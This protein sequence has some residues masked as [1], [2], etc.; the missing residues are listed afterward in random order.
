MM[1]SDLL[2]AVAQKLKNW[3]DGVKAAYQAILEK[4]GDVTNDLSIANLPAAIHSI[5][6]R[7]ENKVIT[8]NGVYSPSE[9]Y[10]GLGEVE[11]SLK[12]LAYVPNMQINENHIQN[13]RWLLDSMIDTSL[14]TYTNNMIYN[15][16]SLT[17]LDTSGWNLSNV[18]TANN[19][20][21]GCTKLVSI[22]S[23]QWDCSSLTSATNIFTG[24][25][26]LQSI[27]GNRTLEQVLSQNI[28]AF[29][30]LAIGISLSDNKKLDKAS[31]IALING[32]AVVSETQILTLGSTLIGQLTPEEIAIAHDKGW[33]IA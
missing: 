11:V 5:K 22:D 3:K 32:L 29:S 9:Q 14:L 18:K 7:L 28:K 27:I 12:Q 13:G 21:Y 20:F 10:D 19:M 24:C 26:S 31:L 23:T 2:I 25:S 6:P 16:T 15:C 30:G 17:V 4:G 1:I 8:E 33:E